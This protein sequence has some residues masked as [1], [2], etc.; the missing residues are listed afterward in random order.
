MTA[1]GGTFNTVNVSGV[2]GNQ[3]PASAGPP[4][5]GSGPAG[6]PSQLR[7]SAP[8]TGRARS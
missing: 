4:P 2:V 7:T 6:V 3:I 1:F 5:P 8:V